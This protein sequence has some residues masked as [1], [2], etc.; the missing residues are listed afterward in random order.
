MY[1]R[2]VQLFFTKGLSRYCGLV[3]AIYAKKPQLVIILN[4]QNFVTFAY[5]EFTNVI[6][7]RGLTSLC[8]MEMNYKLPNISKK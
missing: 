8:Y 3:C 7:C 2:S 6:P 1:L 5:L 4:R